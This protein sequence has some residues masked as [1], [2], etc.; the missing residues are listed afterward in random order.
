MLNQ[1]VNNVT[2]TLQPVLY[3]VVIAV[4][5]VIGA[6]VKKAAPT[7]I[8][9]AITKLGITNYEKTKKT[10]WDIW[11]AIEEDG[12]LGKLLTSKAEAFATLLTQKYPGITNE[13]IIELR[14]AIAGEFNKDKGPVI[15][16]ITD[17]ENKAKA[18][19]EIK[20][21]VIEPKIITKYV[22]PDGTELKPV[23]ITE[24]TDTNTP[25]ESDQVQAAQ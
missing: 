20:Q 23:K 4:L 9:F 17:V 8:E 5:G 12:R 2:T 24:K 7:L 3:T 13:Q 25:I 6:Q 1:I 21:V 22:T 14:Q 15:Q 11:Y 18:E 10:A 19:A 16:E